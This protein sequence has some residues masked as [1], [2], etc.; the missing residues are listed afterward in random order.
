M[1]AYVSIIYQLGRLTTKL[2]FGSLCF[3]KKYRI[4][5]SSSSMVTGLCT[6]RSDGWRYYTQHHS[7]NEMI[8]NPVEIHSSVVKLTSVSR[9]LLGLL[10]AKG[11]RHYLPCRGL[12]IHKTL[13]WEFLIVQRAMYSYSFGNEGR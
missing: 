2:S 1:R 13:V 12:W 8:L 5:S 3:W 6:A 10:K 4:S 11:S 7:Y 9:L